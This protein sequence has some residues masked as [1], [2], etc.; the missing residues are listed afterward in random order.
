MQKDFMIHTWPIYIGAFLFGITASV[1]G[2]FII[3]RRLSLMTDALSHA[4]LPGIVIALWVCKN[5][6][7]FLIA[8]GMLSGSLGGILFLYVQQKTKLKVDTLLGVILSVFFGAGLVL[9]SLAQKYSLSD[10]GILMRLLLGNPVLITMYD[11]Y[12]LCFVGVVVLGTLWIIKRQL[13][14]LLFDKQYAHITV[15]Y[16]TM[17]DTML[18][19]LL[20]MTIAIGL[21]LVGV[22][23][24][25]TLVIA[26]GIAARQWSSNISTIIALA[27]V[28]GGT[29]CV[30][31]TNV[32]A[33]YT[34][35]PAGPVI[36][37]IA[38]SI[39]LCSIIGAPHR[40][41]WWQKRKNHVTS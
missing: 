31:G 41:I 8:G 3:L 2:V 10:H 39:A 29:S 11:V 21:P 18:L 37:I 33:H 36:S 27:A 40:G 16:Y 14:V 26:P 1:I 19:C 25:S 4:T 38:I 15:P 20:L 5:N 35:M 23:L 32:S 30:A 9:T 24:M 17:Y 7:F 6:P 28:I 13:F 22:I 12:S 34:H